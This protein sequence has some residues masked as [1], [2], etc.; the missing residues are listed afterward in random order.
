MENGK[1]KF[2]NYLQTLDMNQNELKIFSLV[3]PYWC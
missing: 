1:Y 3:M 2:Q